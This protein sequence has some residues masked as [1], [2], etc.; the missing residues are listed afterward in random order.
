VKVRSGFFL[1]VF[2]GGELGRA[3][4]VIIL[5]LALLAGAVQLQ[6]ERE[7]RYPMT[8]TAES[9]LYFTSGDAIRRVSGPFGPLAA[10]L[11][12]IRAIQ[13][14][15]G[16]KRRL[17]ADHLTPA[18]PPL[19]ASADADEYRLLYPLLD[20]TTTLDPRFNIAYRFGAVFL[21]EAYPGGPGRPDLA[22][23]L[24]EKGLRARP[25]KWEY[26]EDIGFVHYW[27]L[28]DYQAAAGAFARA[29][30]VPGAPWWLKSL[31]ATTLAQGGDR[32]SSRVMWEA[33]RQSAENDWLRHD[34]EWRLT[35]LQALDEIDA[36]QRIVDRRAAVDGAPAAD[37]S[38]IM[39][40][41]GWRGVPV[42]PSGAP[43]ELSNGRVTISPSSALAPLPDEPA[44]TIAPPS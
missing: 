39:R 38:V 24:L 40:A 21:A 11:Y 14:Y 29:A 9:A 30:Q 23:K 3:L 25:D 19:L 5:A 7:H 16:A 33:V 22:I 4:S 10:D 17:A 6:A 41:Q 26:M 28:H 32:R 37:W 43:Y 44:R 8:E 2:G 13:Y 1:R 34:A 31:A 42:D 18:S 20:I 35:Q 15:G 12:W 27:Y 36:L